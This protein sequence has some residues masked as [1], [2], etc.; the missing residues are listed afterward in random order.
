MDTVPLRACEP[1]VEAR[2]VRLHKQAD[3]GRR[4]VAKEL[5]GRSELTVLVVEGDSRSNL[6]H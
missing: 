2:V 1:D 4:V 6:R 3:W 5:K